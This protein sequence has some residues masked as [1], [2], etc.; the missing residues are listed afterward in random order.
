[1]KTYYVWPKGETAHN[2]LI[3]YAKG[4]KD[5]SR[6]LETALNIHRPHWFDKDLWRTEFGGVQQPKFIARRSCPDNTHAAMDIHCTDAISG[7]EE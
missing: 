3:I 6:Q 5:F 2:P 7:I 4:P 1:M